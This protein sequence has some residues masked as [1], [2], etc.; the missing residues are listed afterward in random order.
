VE[1]ENSPLVSA[2]KRFQFA[3]ARA[4]SKSVSEGFL[5]APIAHKGRPVALGDGQQKP[6][7]FTSHAPARTNNAP[8]PPAKTFASLS[9]ESA[10]TSR[11]PAAANERIVRPA[12]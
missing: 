12:R 3:A 4:V 10:G 1:R 7:A 2:N 11:I 9:C 5:I 8:C 6:F